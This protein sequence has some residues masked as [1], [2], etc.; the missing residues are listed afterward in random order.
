MKRSKEKQILKKASFAMR[1]NGRIKVVTVEGSTIQTKL[2]KTANE[3]IRCVRAHICSKLVGITAFISF[4]LV[5]YCCNRTY[6]SMYV[7][8]RTRTRIKMQQEV[9]YWQNLVYTMLG[10]Y[11]FSYATA[12]KHLLVHAH[13]INSMPKLNK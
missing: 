8:V 6:N 9:V 10:S 13:R 12:T 5:F 7:C 1:F 3:R 4:W 2:K 11:Y